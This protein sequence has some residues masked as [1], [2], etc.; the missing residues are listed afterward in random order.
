[1]AL[2]PSGLGNDQQATQATAAMR[3][4]PWY[5]QWLASQG[6][7]AGP[8]QQVSLNDAQQE[9]LRQLA[10]QHGIGLNDKYDQ[11]DQNGQISEAHHKLRDFAYGAAI[12]GLGATGLGA[13]GIGPLS[14]L[15]G[16][17]AAGAGAGAGV[18]ADVA[19]ASA[20]GGGG[21]AAGL[22]GAM[23]SLPAIGGAATGASGGILGTAGKLFGITDPKNP[24]S[25]LG[26]AG[27]VGD[28]LGAAGAG[29][30]QGRITQTELNQKQDALALQRYNDQ[31]AG[32][33]FS[34]Q[35]PQM[36]AANSVKGDILSNAK[37]FAWGAPS[38][39]GNIPVPSS[40]GGLRPS[41]FSDNTRA[42]GGQMSSDALAGA[43]SGADNLPVP[44]LTPMDTAGAGS[45][46][47]T[48]AG[49]IGGLSDALNPDLTKLQTKIPY[50]KP[51]PGV[52]A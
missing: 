30:A 26:L 41:I 3:Q 13:A 34:L 39:V 32:A 25:Y 36:R 35:A 1:M 40:T 43:R 52:V 22:P 12:A 37:D 49:I 24:M 38:M 8:D 7:Q 50:K 46:Y 2:Y 23:A 16:A 17:G 29:A 45:G 11:I 42:L 21:V 27:K 14:G 47:L 28:A 6:I 15:F 20:L 33:R 4:E 31:L 18:G 19:G 5:L 51:Q 48:T 9:Q 10:I 44:N